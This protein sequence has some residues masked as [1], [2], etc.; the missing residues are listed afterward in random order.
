MNKRI[1]L[2][3]LWLVAAFALAACS[4]QS[5]STAASSDNSSATAPAAS[6]DASPAIQALTNAEDNS[7]GD[8]QGKAS[9]AASGTSTYGTKHVVPGM[10]CMVIVPSNPSDKM[11]N[12][13]IKTATQADADA[14]FSTA[15]QSV[16]TAMPSLNGA[17]PSPNPKFLNQYV[18]SDDKHAVMVYEQKRGDG[19]IVNMSF[20]PPAFFQ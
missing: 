19:F 14:R 12:C 9:G 10:T 3:A 17:Q 8:E 18:Y 7:F 6:D 13:F 5:S 15:K 2:T 16:A 1:S 4:G 20:A 11:A